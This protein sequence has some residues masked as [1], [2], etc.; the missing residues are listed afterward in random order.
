MFSDLSYLNKH[1]GWLV[2][3]FSFLFLE[4]AMSTHVLKTLTT[5]TGRAVKAVYINVL[6][7]N[8]VHEKS[9]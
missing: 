5:S 9:I 8:Q 6:L 1:V 4:E 3:F 2:V 7:R